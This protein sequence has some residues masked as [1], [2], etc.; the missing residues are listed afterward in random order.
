MSLR[1]C[2][3][4]WK[5]C[6]R[7]GSVVF[8]T[9][10]TSTL[11][12]VPVGPAWPG[13]SSP[14]PQPAVSW[15]STTGS[16]VASSMVSSK[17]WVSPPPAGQWS[18]AYATSRPQCKLGRVT[19]RTCCGHM[20]CGAELGFC[21]ENDHLQADA[22]HITHDVMIALSQWRRR[23]KTPRH[24]T[25]TETNSPTHW[26]VVTCDSPVLPRGFCPSGLG[27]AVELAQE[28]GQGFGRHPWPA[29]RHRHSHCADAAL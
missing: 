15:L 4:P 14:G 27:R 10:A 7:R 22:A 19:A 25:R 3:R 24:L 5:Y 23:D 9:A 12:Q 1:V 8:S 16:S 18:G 26:R 2:W 11:M 21:V 6:C 17:S 13:A 28:C 29:V 20:K